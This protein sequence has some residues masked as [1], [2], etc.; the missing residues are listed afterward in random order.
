MTPRTRLGTTT[1][2]QASQ[3][4]ASRPPDRVARRLL[5]LAVTVTGAHLLLGALGWRNHTAALVGGHS[6]GEVL[7]GGLYIAAH[8][9]TVVLAPIAA[10]AALLYLAA[11]RLLT[12]RPLASQGSP[13]R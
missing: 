7:R 9:G 13:G 5:L 6:T 3:T 2:A 8:L 11:K 4:Q 10:L 1:P 12:S